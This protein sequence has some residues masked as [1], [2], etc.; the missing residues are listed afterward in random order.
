MNFSRKRI[1]LFVFGGIVALGI[2]I[3]V[4]V[5]A[6]T[7]SIPSSDG[8]IHACYNQRGNLAVI[9][10][11]AG[12][13]CNSD[14]SSLNW[15]QTGPST[16]GSSG[17]NVTVVTASGSGHATAVCPS[18]EPYV[19][20]GGLLDNDGGQYFQASEPVKTSG[21]SFYNSWLGAV[22]YSDSV[23]AYAICSK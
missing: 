8:T 21:S 6:A 22:S 16:A 5:L 11:D 15:N 14:E 3:S 12:Q 23:T 19:L 18:A 1:A 7:S 4:P 10:T 13:T 17:L 2:G 20:G 9:N